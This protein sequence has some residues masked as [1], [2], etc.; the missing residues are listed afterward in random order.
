MCI[1]DRLLAAA[2]ISCLI[3]KGS[4]RLEATSVRDLDRRSTRR[5]IADKREF[6]RTLRNSRRTMELKVV[7]IKTLL[8][9]DESGKKE[10]IQ[11]KHQFKIK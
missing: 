2:D 10:Y 6:S 3:N 1:R 8:A 5:A 4:N 9:N 7:N 11:R